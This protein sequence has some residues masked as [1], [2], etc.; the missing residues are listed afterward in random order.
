[1]RRCAMSKTPGAASTL[2]H[3]INPHEPMEC[4]RVVRAGVPRSFID[5]LAAVFNVPTSRLVAL[6]P[7]SWR[8]IQRRKPDDLLDQEISD[9]LVQMA[10]MYV[11]AL[12]VFEDPAKVTAWF[13]SVC[14]YIGEKP[15]ALLGTQTGIEVVLDELERIEY[16]A[17][18]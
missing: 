12:E 5:D 10:R 11:R 14:P 6:L 7:L 4:L 18:A 2:F 3:D 17:A 15:L 9:R 8:T 1:M 13:A 16:G